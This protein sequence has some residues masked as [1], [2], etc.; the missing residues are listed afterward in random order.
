MSSREC[1]YI[2]TKN[3]KHGHGY[4]LPYILCGI[5]DVDSLMADMDAAGSILCTVSRIWRLMWKQFPVQ[6]ISSYHVE[7]RYSIVEVAQTDRIY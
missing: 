5:E 4:K 2:V 7:A 6:V 1:R 3:S